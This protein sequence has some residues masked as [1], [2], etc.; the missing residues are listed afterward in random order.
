MLSFTAHG[1]PNR[2]SPAL[3]PDPV[4]VGGSPVQLAVGPA[5]DPD[6]VL[7]AGRDPFQDEIDDLLRP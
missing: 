5:R 2:G 4:Q 6:R 3:T 7:A 1:T